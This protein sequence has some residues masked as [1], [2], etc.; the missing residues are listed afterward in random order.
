MRYNDSDVENEYAHENR[1]FE[2]DEYHILDHR[3]RCGVNEV[4]ERGGPKQQ[5]KIVWEMWEEGNHF[6]SNFTSFTNTL[7]MC[8]TLNI[9]KIIAGTTL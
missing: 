3:Y 6:L 5:S 4:E 1:M 8:L 7:S 2:L 9:Y